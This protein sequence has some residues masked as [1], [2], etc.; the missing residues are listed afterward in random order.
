M[1]DA[2]GKGRRPSVWALAAAAMA[3]LTAIGAAV[4]VPHGW[5]AVGVDVRVT[6]ADA[7]PKD[8][9][10]PGD[11]AARPDLR[12][13]VELA[14][15]RT[16]A[17]DVAEDW[18][19]GPLRLRS[20]AIGPLEEVVAVSLVD[21]DPVK[22]DVAER[23]VFDGG[24]L[25]GA[26]FEGKVVSRWNVSTAWEW[27]WGSAFGQTILVVLAVVVLLPIAAAVLM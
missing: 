16:V 25:T 11:P 8:A 10:L 24:P 14:G 3:V 26:V 18:D 1:A 19:G 27:F 23:V 22:N 20:A 12:I 2:A 6:D 4:S 5:R 17:S 13:D 21:V 7:L 9:A 15:R